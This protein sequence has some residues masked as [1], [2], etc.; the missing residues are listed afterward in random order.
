VAYLTET[1]DL[2]E[3]LETIGLIGFLLAIILMSCKLC[4]QKQI[5]KMDIPKQGYTKQIELAK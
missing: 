1:I 5:I 3:L 4:Y 2:I